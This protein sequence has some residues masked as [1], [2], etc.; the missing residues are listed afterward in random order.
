MANNKEEAS[1]LKDYATHIPLVRKLVT[2]VERVIVLQE[3]Q[4]CLIKALIK[5]N[6]TCANAAIKFTED[7]KECQK[8]SGHL[9][10]K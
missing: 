9:S 7:L 8:A 2:T 10:K 3:K 5:Y 6:K 4:D 1:H